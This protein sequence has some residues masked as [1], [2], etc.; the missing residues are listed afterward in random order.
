MPSAR[1]APPPAKLSL[2]D[3]D[4]ALPA[5]QIAQH[6]P[7]QRDGARL[8]DMRY[9]APR[10]AYFSSL[11]ELLRAG[12]ILVL[13]DSKVIPARLPGKKESGGAA[14][15]FAE[16]FLPGG[17]VLALVRASKPP[18]PGA[19]LFAGGGWF[20]VCKK[21]A[22]GFYVLRA[23]N[24]SGEPIGARGRF[25]RRGKT[26]LPPYIRRP[27]D[28]ADGRRYQTVFAR[29][30]GSV[31]APTA[32]LHFTPETFLALAARGIKTAK[33]TLHVG[34]GTF[35]PPRGGMPEKLHAERYRI[36][37]AAAAQINAAKRRGGRIV[38]AGTTTLRALE[39]A[40]D[41]NGI[42]AAAAETELFIKPGRRFF[43]ADLLL[44]NFHLPR[45]TLL[46]LACA[47]GGRARV[48]DGYRFAV[49]NKFRFYSYGDAM[50]LSRHDI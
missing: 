30:A 9:T 4:Y 14:E 11:P 36:S 40:A 42:R 46:V 38:A 19:R 28:A 6:P 21:T 35:A 7:P 49:K 24:R 23:E 15:I 32:G 33:I 41:K 43:A 3:F 5:A 22:D 12:D 26:P 16:R 47:F 20:S 31:A 13:N 10:R 45:S 44:T 18:K 29:R 37:A 48:L 1:H 8:L 50:L 27:P 17:E 39:S 34:A 2:D 25:M